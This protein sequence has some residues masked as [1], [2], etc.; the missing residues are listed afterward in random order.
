MGVAAIKPLRTRALTVRRKLA[1]T[2]C[3]V[4]HDRAKNV[5]G[6]GIVSQAPANRPE[7]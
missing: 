2:Q 6:G 5:I 3:E 4:S 1:R 7:I